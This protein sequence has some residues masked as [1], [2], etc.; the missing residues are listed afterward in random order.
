MD[1]EQ[2]DGAKKGINV[3]VVEDERFIADLYQRALEKAGYNV[4]VSGDGGEAPK[5]GTD[6]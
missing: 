1:K 6:R 2:A 5:R 3:L 4:T